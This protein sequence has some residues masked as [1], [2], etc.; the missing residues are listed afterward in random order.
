MKKI[1]KTYYVVFAIVVLVVLV[2]FFYQSKS[3]TQQLTKD[4]I[5]IVSVGQEKLGNQVRFEPIVVSVN[6]PENLGNN[7]NHISC[8]VIIEGNTLLSGIIFMTGFTGT[9]EIKSLAYGAVLQQ[10]GFSIKSS[11]DINFCCEDICTVKTV[12]VS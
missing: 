9:Y 8:E 11:Y 1:N 7:K 6:V 4:D 5:S 3:T 12:S 2:L 10:W